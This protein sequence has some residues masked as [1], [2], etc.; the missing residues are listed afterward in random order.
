[1]SVRS[2]NESLVQAFPNGEIMAAIIPRHRTPKV[3]CLALRA[4]RSV[5]FRYRSTGFRER[6]DRGSTQEHA[7]D[8]HKEASRIQTHKSRTRGPAL[9]STNVRTLCSRVKGFLLPSGF[10]LF[11]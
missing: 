11:S 7:F 3:A 5:S 2:A 9:T 6:T 8:N 4:K 1:M 10:P